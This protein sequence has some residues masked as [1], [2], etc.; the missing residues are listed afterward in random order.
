[1]FADAGSTKSLPSFWRV[2]ETRYRPPG[3]VGEE[4]V[5]VLRGLG[6]DQLEAP[7]LL[8][9]DRALERDCE[10]VRHLDIEGL[11]IRHVEDDPAA[12]EP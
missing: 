2:T 5:A 8:G 6:A 4:V 12:F 10:L 11:M 7:K 3:V 9:V 1:M